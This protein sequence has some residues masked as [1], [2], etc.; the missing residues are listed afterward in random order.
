M[1]SQEIDSSDRADGLSRITRTTP[2]TIAAM[3]NMASAATRWV[4]GSGEGQNSPA[5]R[6]MLVSTPANAAEP[7]SGARAFRHAAMYPPTLPARGIA[8]TAI[9]MKVVFPGRGGR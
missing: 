1:E 4:V 6:L 9:V 7:T 2:P 3:L 8:S 5:T